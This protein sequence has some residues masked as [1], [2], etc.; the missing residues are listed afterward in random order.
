MNAAK[1]ARF[2]SMNDS[3]SNS[4]RIRRIILIGCLLFFVLFGLFV[5]IPLKVTGPCSLVPMRVWYLKMEGS[6][7]LFSGW[8]SK[9]DAGYKEQTLI[10]FQRPDVVDISLRSNLSEGSAV[11][12]GDTVAV[13]RSHE[14]NNEYQA[15]NSELKKAQAYYQSLITGAKQA[16]IETAQKNVE[17]AQVALNTAKQD[18][19]RSKELLKSEFSSV[20]E[21]Q[22]LEGIYRL[23]E[24][25]YNLAVSQLQAVKTG[26]KPEEVEM[27]RAEMERVEVLRLNAKKRI[28]KETY[29]LS[30][31]DGVAVFDSTFEFILKIEGTDTLA[32][33]SSFPEIVASHIAPG[34]SILI[35][36]SA[37][38]SEVIP[39]E[40][41][42]IVYLQGSLSGLV[43][44]ALID[45]SQ[46]RYHSGMSGRTIVTLADQPLFMGLLAKIKYLP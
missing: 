2:N 11:L 8:E 21:F 27:A 39:A 23:A 17:R 15:L 22:T 24:A 45:N 12:V 18:Y 28:E 34:N 9:Y 25:D 30:P 16:E 14:Q 32:M 41:N 31:L 40:I 36:L 43:V 1:H 20:A 44:S 6:D 10:Q 37:I 38:Q 4:V 7:Q 29:I 26:A 5:P 19:E 46:Q 3:F 35:R 42:K 33:E 13:I